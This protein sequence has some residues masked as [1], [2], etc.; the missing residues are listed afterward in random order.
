MERRKKNIKP[1][2]RFLKNKKNTKKE[3]SAGA[4][5]FRKGGGNIY[6]LLLDYGKGYWGFSKGRIE[7]GEEEKDT[8]RREIKEETGISDIK[9][10]PDFREKI[11]YFFKRKKTGKFYLVAKEAIFYLAET[12]KKN[13]KISFEHKGFAWLK[14]EDALKRITFKNSKNIL[15][16]AQKFLL[17]ERLK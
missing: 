2:K 4:I 15:Q 16:K 10:I 5:I 13:V 7:K 1:Q 11:S 17:R 3:K 8:A 6:Y 9:F 14:Y 12:K